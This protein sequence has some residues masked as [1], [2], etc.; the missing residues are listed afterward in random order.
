MD[1]RSLIAE[2]RGQPRMF[3]MYVY[4]CNMNVEYKYAYFC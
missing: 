2:K 1:L 3:L 4:L